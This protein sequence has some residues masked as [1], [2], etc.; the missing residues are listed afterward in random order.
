MSRRAWRWLIPLAALPLLALL[1]YGFRVN[2]REIPSPL[3][4]RPAPGFALTAFDATPLTLDAQ[5]GRVVVVNFWASWCYPA[6][7][8]EAPVLER[9]WRAYRDRGVLV[10]GVDIQ[11]TVEAA[12][13]FIRDFG[14]SFPNAPDPTGKVSVDYGTYGVPETFFI[15]RRGRIRAR[16]VGALTDDVIRAH[17]E[18]LLAEPAG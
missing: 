15:D 9:S 16:H 5:R 11:D 12:Q 3:V 14:L 6:C 2:P 17:V 4:G 13:K 7:Y 10:I 1:A 8:E 18:R